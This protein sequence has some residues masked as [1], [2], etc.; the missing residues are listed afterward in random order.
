MSWSRKRPPQDVRERVHDTQRAVWLDWVRQDLGVA[1]RNIARRP[2]SALIIAISFASGIGLTTVAF[3]LRDALFLAPPPLYREAQQL[4]FVDL[5]RAQRPGTLVPAGLYAGWAAGSAGDWTVAAVSVEGSSDVRVGERLGNFDLQFV[6]PNF[7]SVLGVDAHIGGASVHALQEGAVRPIVLGYAPWQS[8]FDGRADAVGETLWIGDRSYTVVGVM[9]RRFWFESMNPTLY[10]VLDLSTFGQEHGLLVIGRRAPQLGPEGLGQK[11]Q[12]TV[13]AYASSSGD[14]RIA[15]GVRAVSGT[16]IGNAMALFMPWLF[17]AATILTLIIACANVAT[18]TVVQWAHRDAEIGMRVALGA[19]RWRIFHLLITESLVYACAGGVIGVGAIFVLRAVLVAYGGP[20]LRLLNLS[21]RPETLVAAALVTLAAGLLAGVSPAFVES[22]KRC[23]T[24]VRGNTRERV[25]RRFQH[26]LVVAQIALTVAL[27]VTV[28]TLVD[29]Y[30][31][32]TSQ[33]L[34]FGAGSLASVS[35]RVEPGVSRD[36]VRAAT[37]RVPGVKTVEMATALPF[38]G[39]G[40]R[41]RAAVDA[42]GTQGTRVEFV[43]IEPGFFSA[44]GVPLRAGRTFTP[45]EIASNAPVLIVTEDLARRLFGNANPVGSLLWLDGSPRSIVGVTAKYSS[46]FNPQRPASVFG[47]LPPSPAE[48]ATTVRFLLRTAN[49]PAET[50]PRVRHELASV[51]G[52]RV[53]EAITIEGARTR[54]SED[55]LTL[56]YPLIPLNVAGL[57][58]T[59]AGIYGVLAFSVAQQT[60]ALAVRIAIGATLWDLVRCIGWLGARLLICG[61]VLAVVI[62]FALTRIVRATGGG[63]S[64]LDTPGWLAFAVP[65]LVVMGVGT[66]AMFVPF[67]RVL[68]VNPVLLLRGR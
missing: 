5:L 52:I 65:V 61:S 17:G 67:Q 57:L 29:S 22:A 13:A 43:G 16:P 55:A 12:S 48:A 42:H 28:G 53:T 31:R 14:E 36:D 49:S 62:T 1:L 9:P 3:V 34:G 68:R 50:L 33:N 37:L 41:L 15:V 47:P 30:R 32:N 6:T 54:M 8:L 11:L 7:F 18:L 20:V 23:A 40:A 60:H 63:G 66:A 27:F 25:R 35:L 26:G 39:G 24:T 45:A 21:V 59:A 19:S 58:L 4:S 38:V 44:L 46:T 2:V 51:G 10:A 56:A 64:P